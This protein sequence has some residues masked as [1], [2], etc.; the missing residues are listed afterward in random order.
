MADGLSIF[1]SPALQALETEAFLQALSLNQELILLGS[2]IA[3]TRVAL[4]NTAALD[5]EFTSDDPL[6]GTD[7][8]ASV[9][10]SQ[11]HQI[12]EELQ[13]IWIFHHNGMQNLRAEVDAAMSARLT[14]LQSQA[15]LFYYALN[16]YAR[17]SM[18][19]QQTQE[20]SDIDSNSTEIALS[21]QAIISECTQVL[22][23]PEIFFST[24][25]LVFPLFMVGVAATDARDKTWVL[26]ALTRAGAN[27]VGRNCLVVKAALQN[28]YQ[29][30]AAA[31]VGAILPTTVVWQDLLHGFGVQVALFGF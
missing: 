27:T 4:K 18:W 25:F 22:N 20:M 19:P 29:H 16:I 7:I 13:R 21:I 15:T 9:R 24:G 6:S 2:T 31:L 1:S 17:T 23:S 12:L 5:S 11:V 14:I 10:E 30:Q 28:I 26:D 8:Q 3:R